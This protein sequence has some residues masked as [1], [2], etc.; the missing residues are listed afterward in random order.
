MFGVGLHNLATSALPRRI[1]MSGSL[2][3]LSFGSAVGVGAADITGPIVDVPFTGYSQPTHIANGIHTRLN[4]RAFIMGETESDARL[5][6]VVTDLLNVSQEVRLAVVDN[7]QAEHGDLYSTDNVVIS[8]THTHSSPG[9]YRHDGAFRDAYFQTVVR[10][11]TEAIERAHEDLAPGSISIGEGTVDDAGVKGAVITLAA[12]EAVLREGRP[13]AQLE[14]A[15][16]PMYLL[17]RYQLQAVGKYLGG[18]YFTYA[19]RGDGQRPTA[20]VPAAEQGRAL[21]L[22][23]ATLDP[24]FLALDPALPLILDLQG[25]KWRLGDFPPGELFPGQRVTLVGAVAVYRPH[26]LPVPHPDFFQAAAVSSG[27]IVLDGG[28]LALVIRGEEPTGGL[29]A[30]RDRT[31]F[32]RGF[33]G[34][35]GGAD[36][37]MISYDLWQTR[38][39]GSEEILG[40]DVVV[41]G[42]DNF[43]TRYLVNDFAVKHG[44]PYV[45]G[46]AVGTAG[47][48]CTSTRRL[49]V[50]ESMMAIGVSVLG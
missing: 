36:A 35:K 22:L 8:A 12:G 48:R 23:L 5:V 13:L 34:P 32:R 27:E 45:Y 14:E 18:Q 2:W 39:G 6:V 7:L 29:L 43:P 46:G 41:D 31:R 11:V 4:A 30:G 16:V 26:L 49:F 19:M 20:A 1:C 38:F 21:D 42:T 47:Q 3:S 24:E 37:V 44:V 28:V 25:S 17:H 9:G 50:P 15:L 33:E 40:S 10:G